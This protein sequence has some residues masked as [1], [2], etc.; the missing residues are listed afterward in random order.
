MI[1]MYGCHAVST[2]YITAYREAGSVEVTEGM[3]TE[4]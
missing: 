2:V 1:E 3:G 4:Y